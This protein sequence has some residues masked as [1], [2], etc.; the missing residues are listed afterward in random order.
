MKA[1]PTCG[2][3]NEDT[4]AFCDN[5]GANVAGGAPVAPPPQQYTPPQ[6]PMQPQGGGGGANC[7]QCGTPNMP[8]TMFCDNCGS[9]LSN[10]PPVQTPPPPQYTPPPP[11]YTPPAPQQYT[12]PAPPQ[13]YTPP[14]GGQPPMPCRLM[15]AGQQVAVPPKAEA[16]VGRSDLA[17]GWNP[18]V[19]LAPFGGTPEAGVSRKHLKIVWQ[20][21]W[22][23]ED[24]NSVNG[25]YLRGQRLAPAQRTPISNGEVIQLG[26]LQLTFFAQ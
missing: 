6:A 3:Q 5:C 14:M 24:L 25:T 4:A 23:V 21:A 17:S 16:I 19:D 20:N 8:G 13:Q 1:C 7:P 10:Q 26:K 2:T 15:V 18:D 9:A 12:P 11:Q 22:M